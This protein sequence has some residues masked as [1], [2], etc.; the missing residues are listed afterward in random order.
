MS[1]R[2][3]W[4][5]GIH[6]FT[7][8][9]IQ[10]TFLQTLFKQASAGHVCDEESVQVFALR[11]QSGWRGRQTKSLKSEEGVLM[12]LRGEGVLLEEGIWRWALED[13]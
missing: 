10:Q 13:A 4:E 3:I 11:E 6:S 7:H 9:F 5:I 8:S 12:C 2:G 1:S